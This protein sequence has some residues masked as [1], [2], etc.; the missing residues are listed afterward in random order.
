MS[1]FS[2]YSNLPYSLQLIEMLLEKH[3]RISDKWRE[4]IDIAKIK[5]QQDEDE[6][7]LRN[8]A[9]A[10][11]KAME[12]MHKLLEIINKKDDDDDDEVVLKKDDE[13]D[14]KDDDDDDDDDDDEEDEDD[15]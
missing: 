15:E 5:F 14:S 4:A 11:E 10:A 13:N 12:H 3:N 2:G 7:E 1:G 9:K 6:V 8:I